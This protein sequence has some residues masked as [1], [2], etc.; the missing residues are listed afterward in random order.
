MSHSSYTDHYGTNRAKNKPK[1]APFCIPNIVVIGSR[2]RLDT[3]LA[4]SGTN[5]NNGT[6][7]LPVTILRPNIPP[8][9]NRGK[10]N[11]VKA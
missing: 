9:K 10:T 8:P 1:L 6:T 5:V 2:L 3:I 7:L 4:T 11:R